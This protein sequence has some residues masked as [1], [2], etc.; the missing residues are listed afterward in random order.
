VRLIARS[1]QL[2]DDADMVCLTAK[3]PF[4]D[5]IDAE[6]PC[7]L[8]NVLRSP[9]VGHHR[10]ASDHAQVRRIEP[11]EFGDHLFGQS[12]ADELLLRIAGEV[13]ERQNREHDPA[14]CWPGVSRVIVSTSRVHQ[15]RRNRHDGD[16]AGREPEAS[17]AVRCDRD[18]AGLLSIERPRPQAGNDPVQ[19]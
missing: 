6:L 3:T 19:A 5:K 10:R 9:L 14:V 4:Q 7:N 11:S 2:R 17:P 12:V 18:V 13:L 15:D 1:N 16:S 8:C